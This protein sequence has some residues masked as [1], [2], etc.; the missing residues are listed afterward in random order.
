MRK[1]TSS[2]CGHYE[3]FSWKQYLQQLSPF[4]LQEVSLLVPEFGRSSKI[5]R[6]TGK[7]RKQAY[8]EGL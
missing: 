1:G 6:R 8:F 2:H 3:Y 5:S 4:S 7:E